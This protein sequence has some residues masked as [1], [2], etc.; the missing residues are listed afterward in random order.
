MLQQQCE[1][2]ILDR[3]KDHKQIPYR[4]AQRTIITYKIAFAL[5]YN[6]NIDISQLHRND[7]PIILI[8]VMRWLGVCM[9]DK[10]AHP[11]WADAIAAAILNPTAN[12]LGPAH[13]VINPFPCLL[14]GSMIRSKS[15]YQKALGYCIGDSIC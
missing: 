9:C 15:I 5:I 10:S 7:T 2:P 8:E 14:L 13:I 6:Q 12:L 4:C 11:V 1:T 3:M